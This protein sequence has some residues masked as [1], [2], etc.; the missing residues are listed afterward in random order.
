MKKDAKCL[1]S[2]TSLIIATHKDYFIDTTNYEKI[3]NDI[4]Q[5]IKD[6]VKRH[7]VVNQEL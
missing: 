5:K 6:K 2:E 4:Q 3:I 1:E 7:E